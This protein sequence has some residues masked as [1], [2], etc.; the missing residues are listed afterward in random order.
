M[1]LKSKIAQIIVDMH[2][3]EHKPI[4]KQEM[5]PVIKEVNNSKMIGHAVM[6]KYDED[7]KALYIKK[8][9]LTQVEKK[10]HGQRKEM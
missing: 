8:Y 1:N 4:T 9:R 6:F 3:L 2:L 10:Y 5:V 7:G